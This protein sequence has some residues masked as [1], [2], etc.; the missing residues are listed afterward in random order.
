MSDSKATGKK[1]FFDFSDIISLLE[2]KTP[3]RKQPQ[4]PAPEPMKELPPAEPLIASPKKAI[5]LGP[6]QVASQTDNAIVTKLLQDADQK[7]A[8][9][10]KLN[11]ELMTLRYENKDKDQKIASLSSLEASLK[12]KEDDLT[13]AEAKIREL[14]GKVVSLE[15]KIGELTEQL[16]ALRK[17]SARE[18]QQEAPKMPVEEEKPAFNIQEEAPPVEEDVASIFR[19]LIDAKESA[20]STEGQEAIRKPRSAKLYDL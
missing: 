20:E 3:M 9:I 6:S 19:K 17:L 4:L 10:L 18:T 15:A 8:E 2:D 1:R 7:N 16:G 12:D 11:N 14:D 5:E 13:L